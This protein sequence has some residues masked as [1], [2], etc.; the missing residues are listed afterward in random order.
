M[1]LIEKSRLNTCGMLNGRNHR[2]YK[3]GQLIIWCRPIQIYTIAVLVLR[4][5]EQQEIWWLSYPPSLCRP[6]PFPFW[7]SSPLFPV[8]FSAYYMYLCNYANITCINEPWTG[9]E[10]CRN[11]K[12]W[13]SKIWH[14]SSTVNSSW[15]TVYVTTVTETQI[16]ILYYNK[17]Q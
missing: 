11:K 17:N 16:S 10:V 2:Q 3:L 15:T 13:L 9:K 8:H 12:K 4:I 6:T 5:T 1:F 14:A 7:H